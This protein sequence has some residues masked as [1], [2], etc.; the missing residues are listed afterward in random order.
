MADVNF[1]VIMDISV[2]ALDHCTRG[3][4]KLN[5]MFYVSFYS[6]FSSQLV[7]LH[8]LPNK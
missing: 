3:S 5:F 7:L 8:G 6:H 1:V 2:I 4:V